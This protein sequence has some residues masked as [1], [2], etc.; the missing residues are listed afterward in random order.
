MSPDARSHRLNVGFVAAAVSLLLIAAA[1]RTNAADPQIASL[2]PCGGQR[3]TGLE[4]E[5]RGS[6]LADIA[7][8]LWYDSS[9]WLL[10][11]YLEPTPFQLQCQRFGNGCRRWQFHFRWHQPEYGQDQQ[12]VLLG[13]GRQGQD[14]GQPP[15]QDADKRLHITRIQHPAT[16]L[17]ESRSLPE[18]RQCAQV[19]IHVD[20]SN[21]D[22]YTVCS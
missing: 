15:E 1:S 8:I 11:M 9:C 13:R 19:I 10:G 20:A 21:L 4:V 14:H 17:P 22:L 5:L 3:G 7:E 2:E 12:P 18:E 16:S 6:R